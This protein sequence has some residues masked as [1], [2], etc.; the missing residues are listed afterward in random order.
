LT[1][2][3]CRYLYQHLQTVSK[4]EEKG[5]G[6]CRRQ[7]IESMLRSAL[8]KAVN[9]ERNAKAFY[10]SQLLQPATARTLD[11]DAE[12]WLQ[13]H[14]LLGLLESAAA[15][16][17]RALPPDPA[18]ELDKWLDGLQHSKMRAGSSAVAV[19]ESTVTDR[20]TLEERDGLRIETAEWC[21]RSVALVSVS[22]PSNKDRAAA[23]A[24]ACI[25]ALAS[26]L[27][28]IRHPGVVP[29]LGYIP[30]DAT[31]AAV[32]IRPQV[33][34]NSRL[35]EWLVQ[36]RRQGR[37]LTTADVAALAEGVAAALDHLHAVGVLV[38]ALPT[39][40]L[41]LEEPTSRDQAGAA[42][43]DTV[44]DPT[45][46]RIVDMPFAVRSAK[47]RVVSGVWAPR[48]A[49]PETARERVFDP[50]GDVFALGAV[51]LE[52]CLYGDRAAAVALLEQ[53]DGV[54]ADTPCIH[55]AVPHG[56]WKRL[57]RPCLLWAETS[58]PSAAEVCDIARRLRGERADVIPFP[59]E[60]VS[61]AG[62]H[63]MASHHLPP[64]LL[65]AASADVEGLT[66]RDWAELVA[67]AGRNPALTAVTVA[68]STLCDIDAE[69]P[70]LRPLEGVSVVAS[71]A[72]SP[73]VRTLRPCLHSGLTTLEFVGRCGPIRAVVEAALSALQLPALRALALHDV[74]MDD[75]GAE[76]LLNAASGV[77][78]GTTP[79]LE[80][81][82]CGGRSTALRMDQW[83][84]YCS[85][86]WQRAAPLQCLDLRAAPLTYFTVSALAQV[87]RQSAG[88]RVLDL[89]GIA[90]SGPSLQLL[91]AAVAARAHSGA[92]AV[93]ID[94]SLAGQH[95]TAIR[96]AC[97]TGME[98]CF[99]SITR[100]ENG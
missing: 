5:H 40:Q 9:R 78:A 23:H 88:L 64:E 46:V 86:W 38:R 72:E 13:R 2:V 8:S 20:V 56:L 21:G 55:P 70:I 84:R 28:L 97:P 59:D 39:S 35:P 10:I 24:A 30:G 44:V 7:P 79:R 66:A 22:R 53:T 33:P 4:K 61:A 26:A 94:A 27:P 47:G 92:A 75:A 90:L 93:L 76:A 31:R 62:L 57:L 6:G 54:A 15:H 41:A 52:C 83:A 100:W 12:V 91:A 17:L 18:E 89:R 32:I 16:L 74:G 63:R 50:A 65:T 99:P 51:V 1:D 42:P 67:V 11:R 81:F 3:L 45:A 98:E 68:R 29:A 82:A 73:W 43:R 60:P 25:A 34:H 96:A 71:T 14:D 58:R 49:P 95:A 48:P 69:V 77:E 85:Q 36:R 19:E 80:M 37:H 87:L